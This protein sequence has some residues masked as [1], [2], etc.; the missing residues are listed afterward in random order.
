[1]RHEP[2]WR[3]SFRITI[4]KSSDG[5]IG[6][7]RIWRTISSQKRRMSNDVSGR[8]LRGHLFRYPLWEITEGGSPRKYIEKC[9]EISNDKIKSIGVRI[10]YLRHYM[11]IEWIKLNWILFKSV[12][13]KDQYSSVRQSSSPWLFLIIQ[14]SLKLK[15]VFLV[16]FPDCCLY[17]L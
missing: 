17:R 6:T 14:L 1:M 9:S 8:S 4:K 16:P 12:R 11:A 7:L 10:V 2:I 15:T 3:S 13:M 5:K